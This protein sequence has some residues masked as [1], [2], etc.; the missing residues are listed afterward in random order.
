MT[1]SSAPAA[2]ARAATLELLSARLG[3]TRQVVEDR[4]NAGRKTGDT[5]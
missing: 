5:D 2:T 1:S 4:I 3:V